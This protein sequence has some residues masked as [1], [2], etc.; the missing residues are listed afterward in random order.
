MLKYLVIGVLFSGLLTLEAML[1]NDMALGSYAPDM[2]LVLI[3]VYSIRGDGRLLAG[4]SLL[5]GF[6]KAAG[7]AAPAGPYILAYLATGFV[8]IKV[9]SFFFMERPLTQISL[10][11]ILGLLYFGVMAAFQ[12]SGLV[13]STLDIHLYSCLTAAAIVPVA[14]IVYGRLGPLRRKLHP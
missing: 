3:L 12:R 9:R 13:R 5:M 2:A 14:S 7:C 10:G 11:L 4:L 8:L 6:V 1:R